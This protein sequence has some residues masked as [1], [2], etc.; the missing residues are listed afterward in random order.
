MSKHLDAATAYALSERGDSLRQ[1]SRNGR[2][3]TCAG[4]PR[5]SWGH[6]YPEFCKDTDRYDH[7][8][9]AKD[10]AEAYERV[11]DNKRLRDDEQRMKR[12]ARERSDEAKEKLTRE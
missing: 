8:L 9:T 3:G 11:R 5:D 12:Q 1:F 10:L 6:V 2:W 4:C 7:Q